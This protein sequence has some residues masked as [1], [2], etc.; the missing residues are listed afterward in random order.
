M[1]DG[2]VGTKIGRDPHGP[3]A[4]PRTAA[5]VA[6]GII[7]AIDAQF[8]W[9]PAFRAEYL[10]ILQD[11]AQDQPKWL[12]PWFSFWINFVS[13]GPAVFATLTAILETFVAVAL[14]IGFA[15]K[16]TYIV[17]AV[18][19]FLIWSTAE[20]FGGPYTA[21]ATDVDCAIIYVIT[22]LVLLALNYQAGPSRFSVDRLIEERLPWWSRIAEVGSPRR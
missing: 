3:A 11:A 8:K 14:L 6:F 19:S 9:Q 2:T 22:F 13:L 12:V 7:W 15:R 4:W 18:F 17:A 16:L 5:R 1:G 21:G 20:G 10:G